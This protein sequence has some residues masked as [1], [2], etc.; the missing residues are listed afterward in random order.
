MGSF[1]QLSRRVWL[2][3]F[4]QKHPCRP[5][6]LDERSE[7]RERRLRI[8]LRETRATKE[9]LRKERR[10]ITISEDAE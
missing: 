3:S 9:R 6:S 7:I 8:R 1:W 5:C 10:P 4:W 2:G